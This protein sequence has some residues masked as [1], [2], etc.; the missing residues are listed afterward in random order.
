[1]HRTHFGA[2]EGDAIGFSTV[3]EWQANGEPGLGRPVVTEMKY[4]FSGET[5]GMIQV[6]GRKLEYEL[7]SGFRFLL[8]QGRPWKLP[9][10]CW[11]MLPSGP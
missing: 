4:R 8:A 7:E 6:S 2:M 3:I 10:L 5:F 1:M 11:Y 9:L